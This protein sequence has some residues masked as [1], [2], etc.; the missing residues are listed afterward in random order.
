MFKVSKLENN[1]TVIF[2]NCNWMPYQHHMHFVV[3]K[4]DGGMEAAKKT[5]KRICYSHDLGET[6]FLTNTEDNSLVSVSF[7]LF[8]WGKYKKMLFDKNINRPYRVKCVADRKGHIRIDIIWDRICILRD[9]SG[10]E[11]LAVQSSLS[12]LLLNK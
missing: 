9:S 12:A 5:F 6:W 10:T 11:D 4:Y 7:K 2:T 3:L 1:Q 8:S